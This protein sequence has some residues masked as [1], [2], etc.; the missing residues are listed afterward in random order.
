M[1]GCCPTPQ[2]CSLKDYCDWLAAHLG[3]PAAHLWVA[4]HFPLDAAGI[5]ARRTQWNALLQHFI[6]NVA[7]I[8][9]P[10]PRGEWRRREAVCVG[11]LARRAETRVD[12]GQEAREAPRHASGC[13]LRSE[14]SR[15]QGI[16][17]RP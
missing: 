11:R 17:A 14:P 4:A 6:E 15:L 9:F 16:P 3:R 1:K 13:D 7:M 8:R 2:Y 12:P 10:V 5:A